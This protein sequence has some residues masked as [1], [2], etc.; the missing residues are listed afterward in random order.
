[1][2][3][4]PKEI[5]K[6]G[7]RTLAILWSDGR[8]SRYDV[9]DLRLHCPCASCRDEVTGER[10]LDPARVP[11][12]VHPLHLASVGNYAL[13]I[14]WSD[15]HDTGIYTYERLRGLGVQP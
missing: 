15:G 4:V 5:R 2:D 10:L 7:P 9:R 3:V 11:A 8:E 13:K 6:A 14:R 1:M 12:D